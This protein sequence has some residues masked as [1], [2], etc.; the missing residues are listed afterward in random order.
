VGGR[1]HRYLQT[2]PGL[3]VNQIPISLV[4]S[5]GSGLDPDITVQSA[6]IQVP[7]VAKYTGLTQATLRHL[8]E[9]RVL[10]PELGIFGPSRINVVLLNVALYQLRHPGASSNS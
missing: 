5:S 9:S 8:V 10:P 7:R 2:T 6:L 3:K 4:E 1:I